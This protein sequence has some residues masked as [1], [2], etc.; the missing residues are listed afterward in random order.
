[1]LE[2]ANTHSLNLLANLTGQ[3]GA[4]VAVNMPARVTVPDSAGSEL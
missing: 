2:I 1:V 3:D 4:K